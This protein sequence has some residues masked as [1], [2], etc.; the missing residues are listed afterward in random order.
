MNKILLLF[1]PCVVLFTSCD[2]GTTSTSIIQNRSKYTIELEVFSLNRYVLDE[3]HSLKPRNEIVIWHYDDLGSLGHHYPEDLEID[4]IKI[5]IP[6]ILE[7]TFLKDSPGK[8][9]FNQDDWL[10][11]DRR[12]FPAGRSYYTVFEIEDQDI[13]DWMN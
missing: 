4:S 9:P 7:K 6:E 11:D 5:T 3:S 10:L 13:I 2:P 12:K 1:I 8:N